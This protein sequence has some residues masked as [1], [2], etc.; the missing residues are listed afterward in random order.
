MKN[1]QK[2][3]RSISMVGQ[4]GFSIVTPPLVLVFLAKLA[5]DRLGWGLWVMVAAIVLGIVTSFCSA[6]S[7]LRRFLKIDRKDEPPAPPAYNEHQ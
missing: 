2:I 7:L 1:L 3:V 5:V 6:R 4:L